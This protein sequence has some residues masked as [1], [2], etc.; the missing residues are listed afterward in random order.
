MQLILETVAVKMFRTFQNL[1]KNESSIIQYLP[2]FVREYSR[3]KS[4]QYS[5]GLHDFCVTIPRRY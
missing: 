3:G 1:L 2:N 5:D 4:T